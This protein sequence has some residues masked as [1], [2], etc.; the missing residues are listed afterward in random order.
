MPTLTSKE[1]H[2]Y[3]RTDVRGAGTQAQCDVV[4]GHQQLLLFNAHYDER[5]FLPIHVYDTQKSRPVAVVHI[6]TLWHKMR[7]TFRGDGHY[8]RPEEM[9]WCE[10]N[11]IDYI[12]G[13]SS[14]K[15]LARK[16][17]EQTDSS[18]AFANDPKSVRGISHVIVI[19]ETRGRT[20]I[21][22]V[23]IE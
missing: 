13:P 23:V 19:L 3:A 16:V 2:D 4:H 11:G 22:W 15:P 1:D 7:I 14:T 6:R 8:D 21:F 10:N 20:Q 12:F 9:T 5:C 17:D 18:L